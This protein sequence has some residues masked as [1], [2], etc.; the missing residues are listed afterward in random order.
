[1]L[2]RIA[3]VDLDDMRVP[4]PDQAAQGYDG[5]QIDVDTGRAPPTAGQRVDRCC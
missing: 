4:P 2:E 1:M 3:P 5:F